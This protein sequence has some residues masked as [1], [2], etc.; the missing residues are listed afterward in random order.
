MTLDD[1]YS[2]VEAS[3]IIVDNFP[4]R[5]LVSA[6]FPGNLIALDFRKLNSK[7]EEK[8]I[9]AHEA[10]HCL[11]ES[12]YKINSPLDFRGKQEYKANAW[13]IKKLIPCDALQTAIDNGLTEVWELADHFGVPCTFMQKAVEYWRQKDMI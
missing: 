6:A 11:T 7:A 5:E 1:L 4:M 8:A 9:L 2:E 13:A 3:N 12:F 10:G